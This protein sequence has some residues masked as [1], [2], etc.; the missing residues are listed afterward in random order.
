MVNKLFLGELVS[1]L[2]VAHVV[3]HMLTLSSLNPVRDY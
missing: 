2:Y 3:S 1:D